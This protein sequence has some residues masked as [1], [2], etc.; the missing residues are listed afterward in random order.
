M[1]TI[2]LK[3]STQ[4]KCKYIL[5]DKTFYN[6]YQ[7]NFL[8]KL[9]Q[10]TSGRV[11]LNQNFYKYHL[12]DCFNVD[13]MT[14]T[15]ESTYNKSILYGIDLSS[16]QLDESQL[17]KIIN[18]NSVLKLS[19][20]KI[21]YL[22]LS[23]NQISNLK[24]ELLDQF[25]NLEVL[26][27]DKNPKLNINDLSIKNKLK[28]ISL[29]KCNLNDNNLNTYNDS[30][31]ETKLIY[32]GL[33]GNK[34][35]DLKNIDNF[36]RQSTSIEHLDLSFNK[37]QKSPFFLV[38]NIKVSKLNLEKNLIDNFN[39]N[40]FIINSTSFEINL[41]HNFIR[42]TSL[43]NYKLKTVSKNSKISVRLLGNP[44]V[45]DC[46]SMWLLEQSKKQAI[47]VSLR[48]FLPNKK[49][50][51]SKREIE[52]L[53][54]HNIEND[55]NFN[56][57]FMQRQKRLKSTTEPSTTTLSI[58]QNVMNDGII[59]I[60]D[61]DTITCNYIDVQNF[62]SN[63]NSSFY[64]MIDFEDESLRRQ[65]IQVNNI[66][67][68]EKL[69]LQS[70]YQDYMCSYEDHCKPDE[71]DCCMFQHCHCR[72]ICPSK[73]RCY[74]DS[75][76]E[77]NIIDCSELNF[78]DVP[79]Q[80]PIES[81]TDMRLNSNSLKIVKPHT[82]FGY[83]QLKFLYLQ[84]NQISYLTSDAFEDLKYSLK[85]LN[86]ANNHLTY[87]N[88]DEFNSLSELNILI[89]NQNPIKDID[90]VYFIDFKFLPNLRLI[91]M[92]ETS[93][94]E[95][96]MNELVRY[97]KTNTNATVKYKV[98]RPDTTT[99]MTTTT[100]QVITTTSYP[101]TT[102]SI[103]LSSISL[104]KDQLIDFIDL[105]L[106][107][108][109]QPISTTT[110]E[111]E[112][113]THKEEDLEDFVLMRSTKFYNTEDQ[114]DELLI[115]NP[116]PQNN[117][118]INDDLL[119]NIKQDQQDFE[120]IEQ[121]NTKN[122]T[123][124]LF[125]NSNYDLISLLRWYYFPILVFA[126][127]LITSIV[128]V[129]VVILLA[130]KFD[131]TS[132]PTNSNK[133]RKNKSCFN[134]FNLTKKQKNNSSTSSSS[135]FTTPS[136]NSDDLDVENSDDE[137]SDSE[138]S[139][140][141]NN[142]L[143]KIASC[144]KS[145]QRRSNKTF[146]P[147][148]R[149]N[150]FDSDS[151]VCYG[152]DS[153]SVPVSRSI[154]SLNLNVFIYYNI[155]DESYVINYLLPLLKKCLVIIPDTKF[156]TKPMATKYITVGPGSF[157]EN[158][159][160]SKQNES[161]Y[162]DQ[163]TTMLN[164]NHLSNASNSLISNIL[165]ISDNFHGYKPLNESFVSIKLNNTT[166]NKS[167]SLIY[168]NHHRKSSQASNQQQR[169]LDSAFK[170][171]F[172]IY[173]NLNKYDISVTN[174]ITTN[175]NNNNINNNKTQSLN[176]GLLRKLYDNYTT[177]ANNSSSSSSTSSSTVSSTINNSCN[178]S[179]N[180]NNNNNNNNNQ[181]R[182][183]IFISNDSNSSFGFNDKLQFKLEKHFESICLKSNTLFSKTNFSYVDYTKR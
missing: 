130:R 40:G 156:I 47:K 103:I 170:N 140:K 14:Q 15:L 155:L 117:Q 27:L 80:V 125:F 145:S 4:T 93:L 21:R 2:G 84:N 62:Q 107:E 99:S 20:T 144:F 87:L 177:K 110:H 37:I 89:L 169:M 76:L 122:K 124:F 74:F 96:K 60:L 105:I 46:N 173:I 161:I 57:S 167:N 165:V 154:Q 143:G 55:P 7:S 64:D 83:G 166:N 158:T 134:I 135:Y 123:G 180:N 92:S 24:S 97:S 141:Q 182:N 152:Y 163:Q 136:N 159:T 13:L 44:L 9:T 85:L 30:S 51:K 101:L 160:M 42:N 113:V 153:A 41:K 175:N 50:V 23:D 111:P 77:Q 91:Y 171:S 162:L 81:A 75:K 114:Q 178:T 88:G 39:I 132:P 33:S 52:E 28:I 82:F 116:P 147:C 1:N 11:D 10:I 5:I 73:C 183:S 129:I 120:L 86:L 168:T 139:I 127:C 29:N 90:N 121:P 12:D 34:L 149:S 104:P 8:Y 172:K 128:L 22:N 25:T 31:S 102:T 179:C 146:K 115:I 133:K 35:N 106:L 94:N 16:N 142:L 67:Y 65:N 56:D 79:N 118:D 72:S 164:R 181:N 70:Q 18:T 100:T 26:I 157:F 151:A 150:S 58:G 119:L 45:C 61:F 131:V 53:T 148:H 66:R 68:K 38:Q 98:D 48:S 59:R 95:A 54:Y 78:I 3:A 174:S 6:K 19:P 32:L 43:D 109:Q 126:I 71:C 49:T 108:K 176:Q 69:I 17:E 112:L 36:I 138:S 63:D 137:D